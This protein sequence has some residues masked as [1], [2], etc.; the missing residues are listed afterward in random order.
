[1]YRALLLLLIPLQVNAI[2]DIEAK[3]RNQSADGWASSINAG[4]DAAS[5][6]SKKRNWNLGLNTGW[7]NTDHQVFGWYARTYESVNDD[8]VTDTTFS[9]LRYV[10][11]YRE[12]FG[13]ET[14]LQYERD[15]FAALQSRF[16]AGAGVR[17]Q[18]FWQP[19]Q[20]IRQGVGLFHE[21]VEE[22]NGDGAIEAQLT[23]ANL[24]TH[25]ETPFGL[26]KL[27]GTVY[28]QPSIDDTEDLRALGR[29][30][31]SVPVA[32]NTDLSW[33]WQARWD[34]KPPEGIERRNITTQFAVSVR[35]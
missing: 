26:G 11:H 35:F 32:S 22:T 29:L 33:Q 15:P 17:F 13:Q 28:L 2:T 18:Y 6:N 31:Y 10:R 27:A 23:R 8:S 7:Q 12:T 20:L 34:S 16:L 3:R 1:M 21:Q 30:S 14:F 9:H 25:G 4:F 5:G 24:Y 19:T